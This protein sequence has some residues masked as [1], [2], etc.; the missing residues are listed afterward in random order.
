MKFRGLVAVIVPLAAAAG[1][2][3]GVRVTSARTAATPPPTSWI[4]VRA[5]RKARVEFKIF[6]IKPGTVSCRI[7][8]GG[9]P[10]AAANP[11]HGRCSTTLADT[12]GHGGAWIVTFTERWHTN[13]WLAHIWRVRVTATSKIVWIRESGAVAPQNWR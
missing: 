6:P 1:S 7:P 3:A 8:H 2:F 13:H 5:V 12:P 4:P 10:V 9:N 11:L